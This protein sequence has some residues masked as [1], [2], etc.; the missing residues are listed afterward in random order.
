MKTILV[1]IDFSENSRMALNSA[2]LLAG[3]MKYHIVLLHVYNAS[4]RESYNETHNVMSDSSPETEWEFSKK[5]LKKWAEEVINKTKI[6]CTTLL[7]EGVTANEILEIAEKTKAEIIIMGTKRQSGIK[8]IINGSVASQ[9]VKESKLPVLVVPDK[10][11][12]KNKI[13]TTVLATDYHDSDLDAIKFLSA[14]GKIFSS[15]IIVV[16]IEDGDMND[17]SEQ[18]MLDGF[19]SK[20]KKTIKNP[21]IY[22]QLVK[23][24]K[25]TGDALEDFIKKTKADL[26]AVSIRKKDII[27]KLF[28]PGI[29][30]EMLYHTPV[31]L[32]VFRASDAVNTDLFKNRFV[33]KEAFPEAAKDYLLD[34]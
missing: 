2:V 21:N 23:S 31:P 11:T 25:N 3:K 18:D 9:V 15:K 7:V 16:H 6:K 27:E 22:F 1:P 34:F 13:Y 17:Y 26:L 30:M 10:T 20:V 14:V 32:L 33:V 12:L 4:I 5:K 8:K 29:T 28:T 24:E 19:A